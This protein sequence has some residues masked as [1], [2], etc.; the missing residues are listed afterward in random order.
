MKYIGIAF[1]IV[2]ALFLIAAVSAANIVADVPSPA[3]DSADVCVA[4]FGGLTPPLVSPI[5]VD[6]TLGIAADKFRVC[7]QAIPPGLVF[8]ANNVTLAV[9][10]TGDS[11]HV[12]AVGPASVPFVFITASPPSAAPTGTRLAP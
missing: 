5:V 11:T 12:A 7:K 1:L 9:Q 10:V 4:V 2:G 3:D 6:S 8:G